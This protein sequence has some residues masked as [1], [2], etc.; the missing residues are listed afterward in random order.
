MNSIINEHLNIYRQN[1][2]LLDKRMPFIKIYFARNNLL[3]TSFT[4]LLLFSFFN[5]MLS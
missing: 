2:D 1:I 5:D 3:Y 4:C